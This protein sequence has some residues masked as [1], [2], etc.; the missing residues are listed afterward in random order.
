MQ[1]HHVVAFIRQFHHEDCR[2]AEHGDLAQGFHLARRAIPRVAHLGQAIDDMRHF[3]A[4]GTREKRFDLV[5]S[6]ALIFNGVV[7]QGGNSPGF[8]LYQPVDKSRNPGTV[9]LKI[10]FTG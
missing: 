6:L 9:R 3:F 1:G 7:K 5:E 2:V 4:Q 10:R 8:F